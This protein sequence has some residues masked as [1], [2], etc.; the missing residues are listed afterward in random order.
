MTAESTK[1]RAKEARA[2]RLREALRKNLR[3]RKAQAKSRAVPSG[4]G[5]EPGVNQD[6]AGPTKKQ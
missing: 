6:R 4:E 1:A 5:F 2:A 3:R